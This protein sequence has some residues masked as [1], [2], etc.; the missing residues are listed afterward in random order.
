MQTTGAK[1][2]VPVRIRARDQPIM[3]KNRP[4]VDG[5]LKSV[6]RGPER[7]PLFYFLYDNHA[8]IVQASVGRRIRWKPIQVLI[9]QLGLTDGDGKPATPERIRQTWYLVRKEAAK[10]RALRQARDSLP[11]LM[12]R[13]RRP[14]AD[15]LPPALSQ[16]SAPP[17][18]GGVH[19]G[20]QSAALPP[21]QPGSL[22][23]V[24]ATQDSTERVNDF[25]TAGFG[26]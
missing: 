11:S 7:S 24:G 13:T 18:S 5:I 4:G 12:A 15:W 16:P 8:K 1:R 6:A 2:S 19:Q 17:P 25:D 23:S 3:G 26:I 14:S 20:G 21:A 10:Q 22:P 9:S